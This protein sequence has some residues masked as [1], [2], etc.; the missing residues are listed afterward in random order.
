MDPESSRL[1]KNFRDYQKARVKDKTGHHKALI[2]SKNYFTSKWVRA[3][4][5][6][7]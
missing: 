4:S 5:Y 1:M 3:L 7:P 6:L 2:P